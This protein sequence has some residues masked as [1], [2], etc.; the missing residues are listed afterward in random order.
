MLSGVNG[1]PADRAG[2]STRRTGEDREESLAAL[3]DAMLSNSWPR[4]KILEQVA[5]ENRDKCDPPLP[6]DDLPRLVDA[7]IF[8]A[9][10][11]PPDP[12]S[13]GTSVPGWV[14]LD[15]ECIKRD[16]IPPMPWILVGWLAQGDIAMAAGEAGGGKST[17]IADMAISLASG[18]P[19]CGITPRR[20]VPVLYF[21][22][23]QGDEAVARLFLRL[24]A[25]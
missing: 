18:K 7:A 20:R 15:L 11:C 12:E 3:I 1:L 9:R 14:E 24:G 5:L 4:D 13:Q 16:G 22:E 23:E 6:D 2:L 17:T 8:M 21:D 10:V 19:W 25:P